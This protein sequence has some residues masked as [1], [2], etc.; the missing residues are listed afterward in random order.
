MV[1]PKLLTY[2]REQTAAGFSVA[3]IVRAASGAGWSA[4]D[5]SAALS[6]INSAAPW[7]AAQ[8]AEPQQTSQAPAAR[9]PVWAPPLH[10]GEAA[11]LMGL[12][13]KW[14]IARNKQQAQAVLVT[15]MVIALGV[16]VYNMWSY[17]F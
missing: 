14:G 10:A 11:G 17:I 4:E 8:T 12:V 15:V 5:V 6:V 1:D 13:I 9:A 2:V 7:A 3:D 16:F